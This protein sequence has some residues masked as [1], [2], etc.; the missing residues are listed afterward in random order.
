MRQNGQ[1]KEKDEVS[2]P[3]IT[4]DDTF[5][6][7]HSHN[8]DSEAP[9]RR[10]EP[11]SIL[12]NETEPGQQKEEDVVPEPKQDINCTDSLNQMASDSMYQA[13]LPT[14]HTS[15]RPQ[16]S[17]FDQGDTDLYSRKYFP[18]TRR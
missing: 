9:N 18:P 17:G 10:A 6:H 15:K 4:S 1:Q 5:S 14:Q 8:N 3:N 12:V 11:V 16:A 13:H 7:L 2:E